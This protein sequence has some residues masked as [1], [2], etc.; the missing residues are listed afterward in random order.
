MGLAV[1]PNLAWNHRPLSN[2]F[3][4]LSSWFCSNRAPVLFLLSSAVIVDVSC[5]S[6][7]RSQKKSK[8]MDE[9]RCTQTHRWLKLD[10][11]VRV[12]GVGN[13][14]GIHERRER[15]SFGKEEEHKT[16]E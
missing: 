12:K 5:D 9:F 11:S 16:K 15:R 4:F 3:P 7:S 8:F 10:S 6:F 1:V 13:L 2:S 14:W